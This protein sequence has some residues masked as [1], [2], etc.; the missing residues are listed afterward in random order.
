MALDFSKTA[1]TRTAKQ[2]MQQASNVKDRV[3]M[4]QANLLSES[5][6][7]KN[8]P[9]EDI[10][11]LADSIEEYGLQEPVLVYNLPKGGYEIYSGH[12]RFKAMKLLGMK[13]IPCIVKAYPEDS[14]VRFKEHLINNSERRENSFRFWMAEIIAA[15]ELL[16]NENLTKRESVEKVC[17]LLNGKISEAQVYR[18]ESVERNPTLL[19]LADKGYSVYLLS[20]VV[21]LSEEKQEE[22]VRIVSEHEQNLSQKEFLSVAEKLRTHEEKKI[23]RDAYTLKIHRIENSLAKAF[24][25]PET[26]EQREEAIG[27]IARIRALIDS[28]ESNLISCC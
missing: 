20:K 18:Y 16:E 19:P 15:R 3:V 22:L 17:T 27:A 6:F 7:N 23:E 28:I 2:R 9:L 10:N 4:I 11:G 26:N 24:A 12:R 25:N 5:P 8:M 1:S 14:A 13:E 21:D